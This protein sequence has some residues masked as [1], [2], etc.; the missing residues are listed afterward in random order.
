MS[1][2]VCLLTAIFILT[3]LTSAFALSNANVFRA[4]RI[5]AGVGNSTSNNWSGYVV[6]GPTGSVTY[7]NGSWIVPAVT[8]SATNAY[9][10]FWVGIDGYNSGTVE[11]IGTDSD[12]VNGAAQYYAWYEF[13]PKPSHF[14]N[15]IS[16]RY[17]ADN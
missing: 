12:W 16:D 2:A 4:P 14:I 8:A 17:Q 10:A 11:Q 3:S 15:R 9:S 7:V 6:T 13:Y 1:A 5:K